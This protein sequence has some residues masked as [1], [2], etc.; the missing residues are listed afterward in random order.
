MAKIEAKIGFQKMLKLLPYI[1]EMEQDEELAKAKEE[2]KN[3]GESRSN[4]DFIRLV[5]PVLLEKHLDAI[6]AI[7]AIETDTKIEDAETADIMDVL[8]VLSKGLN[9][10]VYDFLTFAARLVAS[11]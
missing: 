4:G 7:Y 5:Y 1:Q 10:K 6:L 2:L 11:V 9:T 8:A 3:I